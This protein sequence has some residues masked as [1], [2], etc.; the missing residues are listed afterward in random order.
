M[1]NTM[2]YSIGVLLA[3][4]AIDYLMLPLVS[5][6][7]LIFVGSGVHEENFSEGQFGGIFG[8]VGMFVLGYRIG[9][10]GFY[11]S[12][13]KGYFYIVFVLPA[14]VGIAMVLYRV[15]NVIAG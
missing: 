10:K 13:R 8:F 12:G 11:C 4:V 15:L 2:K 9:Y 6:S 7:L 5:F 1:P 3:R 14:V